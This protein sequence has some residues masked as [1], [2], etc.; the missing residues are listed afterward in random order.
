[1]DHDPLLVLV[2]VL[3]VEQLLDRLLD[4]PLRLRFLGRKLDVQ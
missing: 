4:Q 1:M 3:E 2:L